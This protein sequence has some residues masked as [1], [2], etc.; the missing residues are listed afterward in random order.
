MMLDAFD[1]T[2]GWQHFRQ[3][4]LPASGIVTLTIAAHGCPIEDVFNPT[5]D[6]ASRLGL[7]PP[8]SR[9]S[10]GRLLENP[11]YRSSVH[12]GNG[13]I[14]HRRVGICAEGREERCPRFPIAP[15]IGVLFEILLGAS[16]ECLSARRV[17]RKC[18]AFGL[19]FVNWIS[20]TMQQLPC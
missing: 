12:I 2:F 4:A 18:P 19:G 7:R 9:G 6:A 5:A 11:Q 1:L 13:Q 3:M 14:A 20:S 8:K 15:S 10:P 16:L 17:Q